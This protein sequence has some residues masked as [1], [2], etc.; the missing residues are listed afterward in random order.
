MKSALKYVVLIGIVLI[1]A[2]SLAQTINIKEKISRFAPI[3]IKV[4]TSRLTEGDKKALAKLIE[5]AK[6]MDSLYIR[7]VWNG[8]E[9]MLERLKSFDTPS[10]K[11][12]LHYF[13]IN[14][15]PWSIIDDN[16]AFIKGVPKPRPPGANYYPEDMTK[17]EFNAWVATL[18][19]AEQ[20][21]ATGF[22]Y[23][24]RRD[25]EKKLM[26]V[27]YSV[28][29]K[30]LLTNAAK[31][32]K[33]AAVLTD[34]LSLKKFLI[35]RA[36]AFIS[37][38]YYESD[39]AWM[40]LDSPLEATIGPYEVSMDDLFN[41]K[42]A[43][44]AFITI[45][46]DAETNKLKSFASYLQEIENNLPIDPKYRNP[47]I[48]ALS[49][50]Q[51]ADVIVT[52]GE[53][54]A[55]VKTFAFNLPNDEKVIAEKGS[56]R[57]LLRNVMEAK[58]NKVLS[59]IAAL[60]I[61]KQ[62]LPFVT[63]NTFLTHVLAHELMHGIGPQ[64]IIIDGKQTTVR[65]SLKELHSCL[66]EAKADISGLFLLQYLV[67]KGLVDKSFEKQMYATHLANSFRAVR[68]GITSTRGKA[69]ALQ[70]NYLLNEGAYTYDEKENRFL[71]NFDKIKPAMK[72]LTGEI[73]TLQAE[74]SYDKAQALLTKYVV[75][76]PSMQKVIEQFL[77]IPV[78]IEYK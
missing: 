14:M 65:Q 18:P 35:R 71:V 73:M 50:I 4:D 47:K 42:A 66:E 68:F 26:V 67:D 38:N 16:A 49:P 36:D 61:D 29:Y 1:A 31:L 70:F 7:Q 57:V 58:F 33:E 59:P 2:Y 55:G 23:V 3:E 78:D 20:K 39:V 46:N 64:N 60:A 54:H 43:F 8:N 37:N 72:K 12:L 13:Q 53:A 28:E 56:K 15:G 44:E 34:N 77:S 76:S 48:G 40:E 74:G 69:I 10:V 27:P 62:Q 19:E 51:V 25:A 21:K 9:K 32:L 75:M 52:G 24:I 63:F 17:D 5:A 11:E 45:R 41:Y 6:I 30:D 22:F